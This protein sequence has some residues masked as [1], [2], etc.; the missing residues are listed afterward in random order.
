MEYAKLFD[1]IRAR[2]QLKLNKDAGLRRDLWTDDSLLAAHHFCNIHREDDRGTRWLRENWRTRHETDS[3]LWFAIL[4]Y[5]RGINWPDTAKELGFPLPWD[6][7]HYVEVCERRKLSGTGIAH[8]SD[9]YHLTAA[10]V[11][12]LPLAANQARF[13]FDPM[14]ERRD[15]YRPRNN[16][17]LRAFYDR[18]SEAKYMRGFFAAQIVADMKFVPPLTLAPDWWDFVIPGPGSK[19]GLN[20]VFGREPNQSW[21][22]QDRDW[23]PEFH[24]LRAVIDPMI[25]NAGIPR[26]S[27]QDLQ[28]CLCEFA[29]YCKIRAGG[30]GRRYSPY[31]SAAPVLIGDHE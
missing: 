18:L 9:A 14:W 2:Y 25:A 7:A 21:G 24:D 1:F 27:A 16:D 26:L 6:P 28:N 22:P 20:H 31:G 10:A 12:G 8:H 15:Y 17:S 3:Y 29:K 11:S 30:K 13:I 4:V 5:R 23:Y 19:K